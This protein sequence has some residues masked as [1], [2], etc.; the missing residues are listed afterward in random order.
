MQGQDVTCNPAS[1]CDTH[2]RRASR[3][4]AFCLC[5]YREGSVYSFCCPRAVPAD[6]QVHT[7]WLETSSVWHPSISPLIWLAYAG[8]KRRIQPSLVQPAAPASSTATPGS[9][10]QEAPEPVFEQSLEDAAAEEYWEDYIQ[11]KLDL[12]FHVLQVSSNL[13]A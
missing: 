5:R 9:L 7:A 8:S 6:K 4:D 13:S 12:V 1:C 3:D 10:Q 11:G 2:C